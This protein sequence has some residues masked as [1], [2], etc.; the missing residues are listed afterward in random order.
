MRVLDLGGEARTWLDLPVRPADVVLLNIPA[1]AETQRVR[2]DALPDGARISV[3]AGDACDPPADLRRE[4]FD[5]VFSNS[6]IEHVGGRQRREAFAGSVHELGE[7]H[8]VQTPNRYFPL[9]P[10]WVFPGFQFLPPRAR[11]TV[12]RVW[13]IGNHARDSRPFERRLNTVL[14]VD[15]LT[16]AEMRFL[17]P[18]SE[19][20]RERAAG[21][22]K[23][24][25][26]VG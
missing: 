4:R 9:E 2:L 21:L 20:L 14:W 23:S 25:I 5:L 19:I 10:H 26:A 18:D 1:E 7:R 12:S 3:M 17:F 6:V 15:L 22:T 13:P 24:L 11:A 16:P 8:W